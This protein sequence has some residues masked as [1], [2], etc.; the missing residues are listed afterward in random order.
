MKPANAYVS[1]H[2]PYARSALAPAWVGWTCQTTVL[3]PHNILLRLLAELTAIPEL[4]LKGLVL[5][6]EATLLALA[7]FKLGSQGLARL[8]LRLHAG[9][10][11]ADG[12]LQNTGLLLRST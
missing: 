3:M 11:A 2:P 7:I 12:L 10:Q 6:M 5:I 1:R 8:P 9:F 4:H